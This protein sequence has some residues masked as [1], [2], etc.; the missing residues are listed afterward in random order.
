MITAKVIRDM[1]VSYS[2]ERLA[3]VCQEWLREYSGLEHCLT[4]LKNKKDGFTHSDIDKEQ[5][6]KLANE[7]LLADFSDGGLIVNSIEKY[8]NKEISRASLLN[9]LISV[10]YIVGLVGIKRDGHESAIWSSE[11]SAIVSESEVKRSSHFYIHPM[12]WR[13]LGTN[14]D[15]RKVG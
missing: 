4:L 10:F 12:F 5:I 7:I 9:R 15:K 6:D 13:A 1:E 14:F 2:Q 3:S 8:L 11:D